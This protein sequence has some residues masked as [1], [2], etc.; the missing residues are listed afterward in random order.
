[1][2]NVNTYHKAPWGSIAG[3]DGLLYFL[4]PCCG[5]S[6]TG[7]IG[8]T[9]CRGC[10]ELIDPLYGMCVTVTDHH[11]VRDLASYI[12]EFEGVRQEQRHLLI[13]AGAVSRE[14]SR[15]R[16]PSLHGRTAT[17]SKA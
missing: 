5:A 9:G 4:T 6:A 10:Y 3:S 1:M 8:G 11:A 13:A 14:A 2:S 17:G 12:A 7:T 15:Q 16:H